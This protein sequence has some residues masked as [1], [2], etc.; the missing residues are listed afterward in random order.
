MEKTNNETF[1]RKLFADHLIITF[2]IAGLCWGLCIILGLNGITKETYAW[3]NLPYGLGAFST[4]IASYIALK[5]NNEVT[6]FK[7]WLKHIFDF[8]HNILSYLL[9]IAL[10]VLH[11]L[12]MSLIGGYEKAAPIYMIIL[13]LP[14]M[15]IG[16]GLEE[17]GWR[18]ITFPELDKRFGFSIAAFVTGIIWA[19]WH[20]P[21]FFIPG[22]HQY[23]KS[24]LGFTIT[25]MGLSF[26]LATIRKVTGSIWL[27]ALFHMIVNA[28]PESIRYDIYSNLLASTI[29]TIVM[30]IVSL[31]IVS[32]F[33]K[34][35]K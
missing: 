20:L 33:T 24:F 16:G 31:I 10:A 27:C 17:A 26:A 35:I 12:L 3:I 14:I 1:N 11:S 4:T 21:L 22:V 7:D 30:I 15:L 9:V 8:K 29:T 28:V 34:R 2:I 25:V 5:K 32:V 18:Y 13:M 6:G 23:G 19:L